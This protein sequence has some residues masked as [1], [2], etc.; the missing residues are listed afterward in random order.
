MKE[1]KRL[2]VMV[3]LDAGRVTGREA[4]DVL[5]VSLRHVWR[6]LAAF[7]EKAAAGLAHH[8][9][10]DSPCPQLH[11]RTLP[12]HFDGGLSPQRDAISH[13]ALHPL[14]RYHNARDDWLCQLRR[15]SILLSLAKG[16]LDCSRGPGLIPRRG[17]PERLHQASVRTEERLPLSKLAKA[18]WADR[19]HAQGLPGTRSYYT[20]QT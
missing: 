9:N 12:S 2:K 14:V 18:L 3:E 13:Y 17:L 15:I 7:Q 5:G 16:P 4:A 10:R 1:Q 6:L 20:K 8:G 11:P 19:S